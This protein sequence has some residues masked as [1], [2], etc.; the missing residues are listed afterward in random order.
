M[1]VD[2]ICY[3]NVLLIGL[4]HYWLI[5]IKIGEDFSDLL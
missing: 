2:N 5:L 4:N 1:I 3:W